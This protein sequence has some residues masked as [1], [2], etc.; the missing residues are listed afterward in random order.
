MSSS[1]QIAYLAGF[2]RS[3]LVVQKVEDDRFP[4]DDEIVVKVAAVAIN[5]VDWKQ[6]EFPWNHFQYPLALGEDVAGEVVDVG[7][8][9]TRFKSGDRVVGHALVLATG[10]ERHA[11]FQNYSVI[12]ENMASPIPQ[13]LPF[14]QAVVLPLAVSTASAA[15]FQTEDGLGLPAPSVTPSKSGKCIV[16]WGGT[17]AVGGNAIQLAIAAG[18]E[19]IAT[20]SPNNTDTVKKLGASEVVDHRS[21][22]ATDEIRKLLAGRTIVGA[23]D[24]I[25]SSKKSYKPLAAAIQD[26]TGNRCIVSTGDEVE[27]GDEVKGVEF[28]PIEAIAIRNNEVGK[29]VYEDFL[30]QALVSGKYNIFP[31]PKVAG[32]GL[33]MIQGAFAESKKA[34][35]SKTVVV[36]A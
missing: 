31:E 1:G 20:A 8:S 7:G 18:V 17:S 5:Q 32:N 28:K 9:V 36:I 26:A 4:D 23:F 16:I 22:T 21:P 15:L 14:E 2:K 10:D 35:A 19:V 27:E 34:S 3:P 11:A 29:M 25:G 30:P 12:A 33:H 13:S 24:A 6:Q